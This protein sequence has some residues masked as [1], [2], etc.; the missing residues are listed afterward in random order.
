MEAVSSSP[1]ERLRPS[2]SLGKELSRSAVLAL[3]GLGVLFALV[4]IHV[5]QGTASLDATTIISAIVSPDGST[6]HAVVRYARLP[7]VAAGVVAGAALAISGVLLQAT[8]RNPLASASTVGVNA[9]A[10]LAVVATTVYAPSLMGWS[11]PLVA[12]AGGLLAAIVVYMLATGSDAAP[13]RLALAGMATTIAL[14]S[15]TTTLIMF[16]EYTVSGLFFWG[17]G[18]LIQRN[19]SRLDDTWYW[20]LL[21]GLYATVIQARALDILALGDDVASALGQ[22]VRRTRLLAT[23]IGV[24]LAA[25]AVTIAGSIAFVGLVAPHLLRLSGV[26]RHAHLIP[27]SALWGAVILVGA[28]VTG[29]LV[30]GP[31]NELPA[32]IFTAAVGAPFLI[33]LARRTG[34]AHPG[35]RA[36]S[37]PS[38]TRSTIH[39]GLIWS[40]SITVFIAALIMGLGFG[41]QFSS[42]RTLY[43]TLAGTSDPMTR[44]FVMNL[45]LP[46]VL[47][48]ALV[49][50]ALAVSGLIIQ[51]VVRNPLAAPDLVGV[52][53]GAG[54]GA[55]AVLI[56]FPDA[57]IA[58]LPVAAFAGGVFAFA[59][60]Y[61]TSWTGSVSPT[62]LVLVGVGVS[63]AA[64]SLTTMMVVQAEFTMN[65]ALAWL[66]GSTYAKEWSDVQRLLPWLLIFL[67]VS[68]IAARWLDVLA[69]GEDLPRGLGIPLERAR[70]TLLG[71]AVALA[72]AAIATVGSIGFVGLIAPHAAR[73]VLPGRH[74]VL[75][76]YAALLG[77]TLL[78]IADTLG[79][80]LVPPSEIPSGLITALIGT[81]YFLWLLSRSRVGHS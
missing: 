31:M 5:R 49:G 34:Q 57:P 18:S 69:L 79:R 21:L 72:A 81:P 20:M 23:L 62:R 71:I 77:A 14:G 61:A 6:E 22:N 45:R 39:P 7:R 4:V 56:A 47:V 46:R 19:W 60:V 73:M 37:A 9:G 64:G 65:T 38:R 68:W 26:R 27:L 25:F 54:A 41:D 44:D 51:G 30:A 48:A 78:V 35:G 80:S 3:A 55:V 36:P 74:R 52:A 17:S 29:R 40:F 11:S 32:G 8:T 67:P 50:A 70:L 59:L 15:V 76:P 10:Y 1:S 16:H 43:H 12:F 24:L 2:L 63:A 53:P 75:V 13:A 33:W 28:D 66:S 58:L 42:L